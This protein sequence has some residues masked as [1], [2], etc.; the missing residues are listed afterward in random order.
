MSWNTEGSLPVWV[1]PSTT[2]RMT[3][4]ALAA[5]SKHQARTINDNDHRS[6]GVGTDG[7]ILHE[8][9]D[10]ANR[11]I[12]EFELPKGATKMSTWMGE[13]A[14]AP[15]LMVVMSKDPEWNKTRRAEFLAEHPSIAAL[16]VGEQA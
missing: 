11:P 1:D 12:R 15:R 6:A 7:L 9:L 14:T 10:G 5:Y 13:H 8:V 16:Q 3:S 2:G 4:E